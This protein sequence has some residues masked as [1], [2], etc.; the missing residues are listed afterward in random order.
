MMPTDPEG[1]EGL[2]L[3]WAAGE[4]DALRRLM[5]LLYEELRSVAH[6]Q[7]R[8]SSA[9]RTLETTAFV[10]EACMRLHE[11]LRGHF[12]NKEH[13]IGTCAML[14]R[15]ILVGYERDKQAVKRGGGLRRCTLE[16]SHAVVTFADPDLSTAQWWGR[17]MTRE[18]RNS[19]EW[20][21]D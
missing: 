12:Q 4:P 6:R 1:V 15:R 3:E 7:L 16:D 20:R 2:L 9:A 10:H 18:C 17:S 13:F 21:H 11:Q 5:P 8:R 14:M 19:W